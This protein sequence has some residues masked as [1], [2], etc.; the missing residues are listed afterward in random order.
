MVARSFG[1]PGLTGDGIPRAAWGMHESLSKRYAYW[2]R[3]RL[4][5]NGG[6]KVGQF[7]ISGTEWPVFGSL[8]YLQATESLQEA[9][10]A[11]PVTKEAPAVYAREAIIAATDLL[12]DKG[13]ASWVIKHWGEENYMHQDNVFYRMLRIGGMTAYTRLLGDEKYLPQLREETESLAISIDESPAGLLDD[14]PGE[15]Y[16]GDVMMAWLAIKRAGELLG[17]DYSARIQRG[18]RGFTGDCADK[19]GLPPYLALRN[20]GA[21]VGPAGLR[22]RLHG[23][24]IAPPLARCRQGMVRRRRSALLA[25]R[26]GIWGF[27]EFPEDE[28][29]NWSFDIDAGPIVA[30]FSTAGSAFAWGRRGP[31]GATITLI[32]W[33]WKCW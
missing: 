18:L 25:Q 12:L 23:Y 11:D 20:S 5:E 13:H 26:H 9:W 14:Y 31:A 30:S 17:T 16:P 7:N 1:D 15:C 33:L 24:H 32:P 6:A 27:L 21:P 29:R 10:E 8:F 22:Q 28:P 3:A 2:A 19:R 4:A